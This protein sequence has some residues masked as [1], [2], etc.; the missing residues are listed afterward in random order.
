VLSDRNVYQPDVW[1]TSHPPS[2]TRHAGPPELAV[3]VRSP[4]AWALDIGPKLRRYEAA[5][6]RELW[7]VDLPV[8]TVLVRRRGVDGT[9]FDDGVDIGPGDTLLS[10]LLTGFALPIDELFADL[11]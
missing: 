6:T 3:E 4:S 1:W 8:S 7:L 11:P 5:G 2:G 9:A 10:P